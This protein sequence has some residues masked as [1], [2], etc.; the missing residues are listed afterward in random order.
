MR[1]TEYAEL[2]AFLAI[3]EE[4]N[5]R[6]AAQRLRMSPSSLSHSMR[7]LEERLGARLLNRTTRSVSPTEAGATLFSRLSPAFAE[8]AAAVEGVQH[9]R[10]RPAG[11]VR[12]N[13]PRA[14][15]EVVFVPGS[16]RFAQQYPEIRLELITDDAF[17][18]IVAKGFDAGVRLG[19]FVQRDMISVRLT[20]DVRFA[21]VA[22]P[23]YFASRR[24]PATPRDLHDHAC[25][26]FRFA[27]NGELFP[28]R[29]AKGGESL[30]VSV[31]GPITT[32]D[33]NVSLAAA[34]EGAGLFRTLEAQVA[35]H[36]ATGRLVRVLEDWC[37]S[38]PGLF[39]YYPSRRQM[40]PAL[41]AVIDFF[42]FRE[43]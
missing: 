17:V 29:F 19:E 43:T 27:H 34:L 3:A 8:I 38:Y 2:A 30:E 22:S 25:V 31:D 14:A 9:F 11:K 21:V 42:R 12:L 20:S 32:N 23:S 16:G 39:L 26:N 40:S 37:P 6:R 5:F 33:V 15:A 35:E 28:W 4:S 24:H 18:D 1:G 41:R 7:D 10:D 13:M 36:I